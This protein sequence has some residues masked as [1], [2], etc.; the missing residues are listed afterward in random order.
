MKCHHRFGSHL[1]GY[2]HF[3]GITLPPA[4]EFGLAPSE[5]GQAIHDNPLG[6][7]DFGFTPVRRWQQSCGEFAGITEQSIPK[8]GTA[9]PPSTAKRLPVRSDGF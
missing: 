1:S 5:P 7:F 4:I 9:D 3:V 2:P 8:L 6:L